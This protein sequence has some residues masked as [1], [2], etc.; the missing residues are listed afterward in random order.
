[1]TD[2]TS[3]MNGNNHLT[4]YTNYLTGNKRMPNTQQM[5]KMNMRTEP[6]DRHLQNGNL[7]AICNWGAYSF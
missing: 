5:L 6:F 7:S 4:N 1:M 3:K 2:L